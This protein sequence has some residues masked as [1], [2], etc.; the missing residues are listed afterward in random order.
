MRFLGVD[1]PDARCEYTCP[2]IGRLSLGLAATGTVQSVKAAGD[3]PTYMVVGS[4][5]ASYC[6]LRNSL[7]RGEVFWR[8]N[9]DR[10]TQPTGLFLSAREGRGYRNA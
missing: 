4:R 10:Y 3:I 7:F 1:R 2:G 6:V 9:E 5:I 8:L